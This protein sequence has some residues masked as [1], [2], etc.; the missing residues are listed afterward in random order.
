MQALC[1]QRLFLKEFL[2]ECLFLKRLFLKE[3]LSFLSSRT[4]AG[5]ESGPG[6]DHFP[7][8]ASTKCA[9]VHC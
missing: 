2:K 7:V 8:N 9:D 5:G 1:Y 3:C 6:R 4:Q